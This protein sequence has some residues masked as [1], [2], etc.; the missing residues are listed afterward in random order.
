MLA[1]PALIPFESARLAMCSRR[2]PANRE[3]LVRPHARFVHND[4]QCRTRQ[5]L[6]RRFSDLQVMRAL[7]AKSPR[8][9]GKPWTRNAQDG[10]NS[11]YQLCDAALHFKALLALRAMIALQVKEFTSCRM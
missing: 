1:R 10:H 2:D 5:R 11:D 3:T 7:A 4:R 6:A 9:L 8:M